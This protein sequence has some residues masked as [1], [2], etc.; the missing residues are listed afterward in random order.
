MNLLRYPFFHFVTGQVA[1]GVTLP[2]V[3]WNSWKRYKSQQKQKMVI[4]LKDLWQF[5]TFGVRVSL[6][7]FPMD[8]EL[9]PPPPCVWEPRWQ[10]VIFSGHRGRD[11][12]HRPHARAL[13]HARSRTDT[14][15]VLHYFVFFLFFLWLWDILLS[16]IQPQSC[17]IVC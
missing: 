8:P 9:L 3:S 4:F 5:G 2:H 17:R 6:Y 7:C 11:K 1:Q 14:T 16:S 15:D 13:T 12:R 10:L